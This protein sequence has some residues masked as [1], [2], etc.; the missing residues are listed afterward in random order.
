[1]ADFTCSLQMTAYSNAM[2]VAATRTFTG[3]SQI[4][5]SPIIPDGTTNQLILIAIDVSLLKFLVI[6]SDK[7]ITIKTNSSG[8]PDDTLVIYANNP[9]VWADGD[10]NGCLVTTDVASMYITNATAD[11]A[12]VQIIALVDLP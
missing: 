10:Y 5:L 1:M 11:D 8:S 6:K 4:A 7:N 12:N 9:Y 3:E 2:S